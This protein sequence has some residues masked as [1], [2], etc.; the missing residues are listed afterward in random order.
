MFRHTWEGWRELPPP[1]REEVESIK[2]FKVQQV[3]TD[4][5]SDTQRRKTLLVTTD[6][7]SAAGLETRHH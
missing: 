7:V 2:L 4:S 5:P 6:D 3:T 1:D